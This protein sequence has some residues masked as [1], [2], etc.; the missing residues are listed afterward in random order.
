MAGMLIGFA[1]GGTARGLS[2]GSVA[3][4][5]VPILAAA[6][7][8][9]LGVSTQ[10]QGVVSALVAAGGLLAIGTWVVQR[11]AYYAV[12]LIVG[13]LA[14]Q[15]VRLANGG[16]MPVDIASL[17]PD[18][19]LDLANL[20]RDSSTY[21]LAGPDT[22]LPWLDDRFPVPIFPGIASLGD[23]LVATGIICMAAALTVARPRVSS[24]AERQGDER[25]A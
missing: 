10:A 3:R 17:P 4:R 14:N 23:I 19:Q 6:G 8:A 9:L 18:T 22:R 24:P 12:L 20:A 16:R 2:A 25:A 15:A 21:R 11:R 13:G 7:L 1:L 5:R